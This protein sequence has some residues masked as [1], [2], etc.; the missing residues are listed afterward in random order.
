LKN[1]RHRFIFL[2]FIGLFFS[3]CASLQ[4]APSNADESWAARQERLNDLTSWAMT[5]RLSLTTPEQTQTLNVVWNEQPDQ[6]RIR[7]SGSFGQTG[8][9]IYGS[10]TGVEVTTSD[11]VWQGET[12]EDFVSSELHLAL[13]FNALRYWLL[14]IPAPGAITQLHI[15]TNHRLEQLSQYEWQLTYREYDTDTDLPRRLR[16]EHEQWRIN[17]VIQQWQMPP[18]LEARL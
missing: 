8:A 11:G 1:N 18:Q 12:L 2:A 9:M 17:M 13:P 14:G 15:D 6:Y 5:A 3:G 7:I 16:L 10:D 4:P